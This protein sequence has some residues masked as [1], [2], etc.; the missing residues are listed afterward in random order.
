[1]EPLPRELDNSRSLCTLSSAGIHSAPSLSAHIIPAGFPGMVNPWAWVL[2]DIL[3]DG[4]K[5]QRG[6]CCGLEMVWL[7]GI[8]KSLGGTLTTV[9]GCSKPF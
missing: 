7:E 5:V 8:L 3:V 4:P 1:M 6:S 2:W 9:P